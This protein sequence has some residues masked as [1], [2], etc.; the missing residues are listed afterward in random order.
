[1]PLFFLLFVDF[2]FIYSNKLQ[3]YQKCKDEYRQKSHPSGK[4]TEGTS[5]KIIGNMRQYSR[6]QLRDQFSEMRAEVI[7]KNNEN[8]FWDKYIEAAI[9]D[10]EE[11]EA[12]LREQ[13]ALYQQE[14]EAFEKSIEESAI[15]EDNGPL[16]KS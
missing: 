15:P 5:S 11:E 8:D 1:M 13:Y 10:E 6:N 16:A 2:E 3:V 14:K 7:E 12:A 4:I 9:M